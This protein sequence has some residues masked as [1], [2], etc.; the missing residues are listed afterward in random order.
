MNMRLIGAETIKDITPD[1][2][3]CSNIGSHIAAIPED[4][5]YDAN[6]ELFPTN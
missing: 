4:R 3:D 2:V 5:L 6:C 1:M